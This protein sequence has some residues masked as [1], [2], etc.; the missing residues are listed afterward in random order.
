MSRTE[1]ESNMSNTIEKSFGGQ[2]SQPPGQNT[3]RTALN[4]GTLAEKAMQVNR[5]NSAKRLYPCLLVEK[6]GT[7]TIEK[8]A[9]EMSQEHPSGTKL[10]TQYIVENRDPKKVIKSFFNSQKGKTNSISDW[11][12]NSS[13]EPEVL[14]LNSEDR[15]SVVEIEKTC[16]YPTEAEPRRR[17]L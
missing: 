4:H 6:V 12:I 8:Q 11:S 7:N 3:V 14:H 1:V 13:L 16:C 10:K 15:V 5:I 17:D 2:N 9:L